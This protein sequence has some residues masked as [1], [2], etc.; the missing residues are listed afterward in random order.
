M[1]AVQNKSFG[2]G[3][4]KKEKGGMTGGGRLAGFAFGKV[5]AYICPPG[6]SIINALLMYYFVL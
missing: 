4:L 6:I 3:R 2:F 5:R 1:R